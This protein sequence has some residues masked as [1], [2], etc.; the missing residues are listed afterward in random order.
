M[1]RSRRLR[2]RLGL[3][4]V[5]LAAGFLV[6]ELALRVYWWGE[7]PDVYYDTATP[8]ESVRWVPHPFLPYAG[9]PNATFELQNVDGTFERIVTNSYGF[10]SHEFPEQKTPDDYFV[11]AFGG[12]TTYG[13]R[14]ESNAHTWPEVLERRLAQRYPER[15]VRVFNLGMDMAT[16][17]F[18]V[19]NMALVGV[20]LNPDLVIV[21]HGYNDLAALGESG[22]RP[23]HSHF[24]RDL[25][26]RAVELG[27]QTRLPT[28][29][30]ASYAVKVA[31][32]SMD[33]VVRPNDL[34]TLARWPTNPRPNP[35]QDIDSIL[36]NYDT[37]R[38]LAA[39]R[40]AE[41]VFSTFQ[42]RDGEIDPTYQAF[43]QHLRDHFTRRG[44]GYVDQDALIPDRDPTINV[45]VCHFTQKGRDLM[46]QNYFDHIVALGLLE[47]R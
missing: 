1:A 12:S 46:A 32:G 26:P 27:F 4:L 39:G 14:A 3:A 17:V 47:R 5:G 30:R 29:M 28:W 19:V 2:A 7:A 20:H 31:T 41:T 34:A 15:R 37:I 40:G 38:A 42:F 43:N 8:V 6:I 35:L 22:Y 44:Y 11:L 21:Y 16:S 25:D 18:S 23:D 10:R 33:N 24:Y 13:F 9:R 45:D 36:R